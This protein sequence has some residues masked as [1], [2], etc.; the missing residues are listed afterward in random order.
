LPGRDG[1]LWVTGTATLAA[2]AVIFDLVFWVLR[3]KIPFPI[4]PR[5]KFDIDG[6][7][8]ILA[9][10]MYGPSSSI[11]VSVI[12]SLTISFRNPLSGFMKGLA[13]ASTA[14]GMALF[15]NRGLKGAKIVSILSGAALRILV[16]AV[17]NLLI[18]PAASILSMETVL[19]ILP[20]ISGFNAAA[21]I[22]SAL[23]GWLIYMELIKRI[24]HLIKRG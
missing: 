16:M 7:P 10:L 6:I 2:L 20:F 19:R 5:L 18:L 14:L 11:T 22:I 24:P 15:Y 1:T 12:L 23:G 8:V 3:I 9:L 13:E 4:F 17:G 21:G